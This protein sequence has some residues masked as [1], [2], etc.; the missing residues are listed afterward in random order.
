M[1]R[2]LML[3]LGASLALGFSAGAQ[4]RSTCATDDFNKQQAALHPR[5][6]ID[7]ARLNADIERILKG[8]RLKTGNNNFQAKDAFDSS[9]Y[10]DTTTWVGDVAQYHIPMV[11]HIIYEGANTSSTNLTD[12]DIYNMVSRLNGYYNAT[13]PAL[14]GITTS[15]KPY[16]G[17]A[18]ITFHLAT[19]D[20]NGK[21]TRGIVRQYSYASNYGDENAKIDQWPPDQYLNLYLENVI[22]RGASKG[23]VLAYATFPSSYTENISLRGNQPCR[24]GVCSHRRY[25]LY[26]RAR[27]WPLPKPVPR[28]E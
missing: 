28:L 6:L 16:I 22:G 20:P 23:I 17:N 21:P 26:D 14:N 24:S 9:G 19:K 11:V 2:K 13:D 10:K 7:E 3:A 4:S 8:G 1:I 18:H 15:F 5:I 12:N 27:N 25:R